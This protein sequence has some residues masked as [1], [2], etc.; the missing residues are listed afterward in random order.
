METIS[1]ILSKLK[2]LK[3]FVV[4]A[5]ILVLCFIVYL[6]NNKIDNLKEELLEKPKIEFVNK[7]EKEIVRDSIP[8]PVEIIKWKDK[9]IVEV[10]TIAQL[11]TLAD[12]ASIA[13]AYIQL[14]KNFN[15][16]RIYED[17][18]KDDSLAFIQLNEKVTENSIFD[19]ELIYEH[20]TPTVYQT[21]TIIDKS[22]SIVGGLQGNSVG[23]ALGGGVV[24]GD[25]AIYLVNYN[26]FDNS[27]GGT[28]MFSL[29]NF[30]K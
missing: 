23:V 2:E 10:D 18:L 28:V 5:V 4:Y 29:F 22:W 20:R 16:T 3:N 13:E 27:F 21:N 9:I 1:E 14:Y 26:L 15:E 11:L 17:V 12:S 25:N 6:K 30:N 19:R 7:V 8:Y 24:T